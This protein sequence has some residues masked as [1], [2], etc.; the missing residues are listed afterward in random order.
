[1]DER[2]FAATIPT[3]GE[4]L[5]LEGDQARHL[6]RVLRLG[7]G[8]SVIV[9]DG[10]GRAVRAIV[11]RVFGGERA[12]VEL[13]DEIVADR[14]APIVLTLATA[15]PKGDRFDWLVEKA[16]ELGAARIAP[17]VWERSTVEPRATK[18]ERLRKRVIEASKQCGRAALTVIDEP[19]A[20]RDFVPRFQASRRLLALP[21]ARP[22]AKVWRERPLTDR[23]TAAVA[24]GP[25]GGFTDEE[26]ALATAEG[27]KSAGLGA[28]ILR[29]ETAAIVAC[30]TLFH[31]CEGGDG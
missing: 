13:T 23:S 5:I 12:E 26:I 18:I 31:L 2:F 22:I 16:T 14:E 30:A 29:V 24:I 3:S 1:M 25:E 20:W 6:S 4:R 8:S 11:R 7:A 10:R 21:G 19:I 17:I 15:V 9:F 28:T 27:W